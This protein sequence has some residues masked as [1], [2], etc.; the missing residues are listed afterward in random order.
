MGMAPAQLALD[1][2][3]EI[4]DLPGVT[5]ESG[6]FHD[7]MLQIDP[8]SRC[9]MPWEKPE[10]AGL[11]L[12]E[13]TGDAAQF[14]PRNVLRRVMERAETMGDFPKYGYEQ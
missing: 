9:D 14:C 8:S 7:A 11:Y 4:L 13:F 10:D 2:T 5:D 1:P 12:A 3:D 6:D